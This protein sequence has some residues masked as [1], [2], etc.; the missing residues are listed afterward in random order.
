MKRTFAF[1]ILLLSFSIS[2][3]A[4]VLIGS[5]KNDSLIGSE[6][7]D[8][9]AGRGG[10][11]W[12]EG[13]GGDDLLSGG[14]GRDKFVLRAGDG[15]DVITDFSVSDGDRILFDYGSYSDIMIFG[16]LA[17]GRTFQ[18]FIGTATWTV[19]KTDVNNDGV[20][21]TTISVNNDSITILN[22]A[23]ESLPGWIIFGG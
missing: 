16:Q 22:H 13:A 11:D 4:E 14:R 6:A 20:A 1:L 3:Q 15:H 8:S 21:D 2:A 5:G 12:V 19:R 9:I 7:S 10:A 23:P 17:D 18:N